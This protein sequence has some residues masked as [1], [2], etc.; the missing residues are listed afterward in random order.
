MLS[1]GFV[2]P[3]F[4]AGLVLFAMVFSIVFQYRSLSKKCQGKNKF[5]GNNFLTKIYQGFADIVYANDMSLFQ[6]F[7][8]K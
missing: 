2:F 3:V 6:L 5:F 7:Y 8:F 1:I 4:C